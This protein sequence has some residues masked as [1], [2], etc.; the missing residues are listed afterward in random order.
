M[1]KGGAALWQHARGLAADS[2]Q[3]RADGGTDFQDG[4]TDRNRG[5]GGYFENQGAPGYHGSDKIT[6]PMRTRCLANAR[7]EAI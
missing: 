2:W 5:P 4:G 7:K 6:T 3:G 1:R